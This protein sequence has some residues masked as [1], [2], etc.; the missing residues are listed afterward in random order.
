M[1]KIYFNH[2]KLQPIIRFKPCSGLENIFQ[3]HKITPYYPIQAVQ[4]S[5]SLRKTPRKYDC[6]IYKER[7]AIE[8]MSNKNK[9]FRRVATKYDKLAVAYSSSLHV[10]AIVVWLR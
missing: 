9:Q 4:R 8:R 3:L 7:N 5:R 2:I 6:H 1:E 10:A